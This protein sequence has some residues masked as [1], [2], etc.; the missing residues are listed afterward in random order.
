MRLD[1][2]DKVAFP[3]L[4]LAMACLVPVFTHAQASQAIHLDPR[5]G[6]TLQGHA[7]ESA[8]NLPTQSQRAI[9]LDPP[10]G[11][12]LQDHAMDSKGNLLPEAPANFRRL[13][14]ATVG[15]QADVHTLTLRFSQTTRITGISASADFKIEQGGSCTEGNLYATGAT[16]S[17]LVRF[18]P[19]GAGNRVGKLTVTHTAS[20]TPDA[21]GLGGYGYSPIVSFVP[22][23]IGTVSGTYPS[24]KGLLSGAQNLTVDGGDTIWIADTGN[25]IIRNIDA[26]GSIKTLASGYTGALGI[27]VDTFG[28]AY[29]DVP[30]TGKMYEIYDYG[31][32]VQASG[33]GTVNCPASAPCSLSAEA[34]ATPGE[35]SM[36]PYNHLFFVDSH[37][38]AAFSTVQ[39]IPANL[40][41]LYDP[42]PYQTSPSSAMAVDAGDNLYSLWS[43]GGTCEIVQ[44]SLYN[45]ENNNVSFYKIAGGHT[46]GFAGDGGLAGNAEIG[47]KIGQIAFDAAGDLY[48]T[49]TN[50][51]RV[52]RIDY[53]TGTIRTIAGNGT[54]GYLDSASALKAELN[55]PT[56]L[57]V[58]SQGQ[59]YIISS[60][61]T[62]QVVRKVGNVGYATLGSINVGTTGPPQTVLLT[63]SGNS[64]LVIS[65]AVMG[66][67]NP[68]EF[69]VDPSTTSCLLASGSILASGQ[70]CQIGFVIRP[71][72]T[73]ARRATYTIT[74][75]TANFS[76]VISLSGTGILPNA[77]FT[78]TSPTNGASFVSGTAVT[79]KVSVTSSS[80]SAPTG[81][82]QFKVDGAN[83]GSA[84]AISSGV[85]STSVTGLTTASHTLSATYSGDSHYSPGGPISVTIT[86][87]ASIAQKPTVVTMVPM[88]EA[89]TSCGPQRFNVSV[90]S[91]AGMMPT[92]T[93]QLA[94]GSR[95]V[96]SA[97][98]VKGK[99]VLISPRLP[100]GTHSFSTQYGGD[101][102]NPPAASAALVETIAQTGACNQHVSRVGMR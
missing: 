71:A 87:T 34:L 38:G 94:D 97:K 17:V 82:V 98:L 1:R 72:G 33:S 79:F 3:S 9:S 102:N 80:G 37:N 8:G 58:D 18:T 19:Q 20:P 59:V 76:N 43:N 89:S 45:A 40:I 22:S 78:I 85:A 13:G 60:A 96:S 57:S 99:A 95:A 10:T 42:F 54:A 69:S 47:A 2:F 91:A 30:S 12:E 7:V 26:S 5:S 29:F 53:T 75:N 90:A 51:Q 16:C 83:Y 27:A 11:W 56:G 93:V 44:Q 14:E 15:Q 77:T 65:N 23:S 64:T 62:G 52:R 88:T 39:P 100:A 70:S 81:T 41:F 25:G 4:L 24:S 74:D 6:G 73:G 55:G 32:V 35:M 46:C 68:S 21:F 66:G 92:G 61:T 63:N 50:N 84:V 49:D 28:Q 86:I 67:T 101:V 36:D 31:P 48:F